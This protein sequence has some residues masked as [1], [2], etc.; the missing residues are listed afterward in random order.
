MLACVFV[1]TQPLVA[2]TRPGKWFVRRVAAASPSSVAA[3]TAI[4]TMQ[5]L[6]NWDRDHQGIAGIAKAHE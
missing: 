2:V 1:A 6:V 5:A 3:D 4:T